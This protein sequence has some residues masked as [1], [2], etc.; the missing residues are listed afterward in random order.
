MENQKP[1]SKSKY[2]HY[3]EWQKE[4]KRPLNFQERLCLAI[5][6]A[7]AKRSTSLEEFLDLMKQ[8]G[9]EVKEVR[10][11]GFSFR[12]PGGG[13]NRF[14]RLRASTLWEGYDLKDILAAIEGG[15]GRRGPERKISLAVDMQA[16]LAERKSSGYERWAKVFNLKRKK[17]LPMHYAS[18]AADLSSV[19]YLFDC[20]S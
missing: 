16:K 3:G 20:F 10:G 12:L 18:A 6:T 15:T 13:Q 17:Q 11:G 19:Y 5:D 4:R 8:A 7:L 9:Y 2:K 1:R 14:T